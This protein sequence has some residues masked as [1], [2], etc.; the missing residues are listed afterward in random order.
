V[1]GVNGCQPP[2]RPLSLQTEVLE[3]GLTAYFDRPVE[4]VEVKV[5][6]LATSSHP[7]ARLTVTLASGERISVIF[8]RSQPDGQVYGNEREVLV[9]RSLL[10]GGRFG[11]PAL[12]ASV[13][14][15][16]QGRYELYLEDLG[17]RTLDDGGGG[18]WVAAARWLAE[19]H[20]A[21]LGHED[22]LRALGCLKEH[23]AAYYLMVAQT[24]RRNL[25]LANAVAALPR[26]DE[27]MRRFEAL[28]T[29]LVSQ[30]RTFV[31]GDIYDYN[32]IV[33]PGQRIRAVDWE[34]AAIGLGVWDLARLVDDCGWQKDV[35]RS[36]Y[37]QELEQRVAGS[38]DRAAFDCTFARCKILTVLWHLW[39]VDACRNASFVA[40]ELDQLDV[41]WKRLDEETSDG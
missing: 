38:F 2:G 13:Y 5:R 11:A 4:I 41:L 3:E 22:E 21:Y 31:H 40:R 9:Y 23:D 37:L 30:P 19:M 28:V 36:A 26:F 16:E 35:L 12:Y 29:Y 25:E 39:S 8:K 20:A 32:L 34:S 15:A 33:Q 14:D 10:R 1:S 24:A 18:T 27:M 17:N 7:I 6:P